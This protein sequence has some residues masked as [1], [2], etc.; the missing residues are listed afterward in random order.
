MA[1]DH[2]KND[3]ARPDVAKDD[4]G[5]PRENVKEKWHDTTETMDESPAGSPNAEKQSRV[6]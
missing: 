6:S 3:D 4:H 2:E 1:D 5:K